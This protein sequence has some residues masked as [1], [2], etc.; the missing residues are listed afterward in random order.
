M[1]RKGQHLNPYRRQHPRLGLSP[2]DTLYGFFVIPLDGVY[3]NV[4]SSGEATE[5]DGLEA[6]EHVSVSLPDR[7]PT[8][9]EMAFIKSLF[10]G[11]W[12]TVIQFHPMKSQYVNTHPNCL[13]LWKRRGP[14]H[15]L[16]PIEAV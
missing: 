7:C 6:W 8:W 9:E 16:P 2:N 10:W 3:M 11:D 14:N 12:E 1:K 13:H 15:E 5:S 4:I